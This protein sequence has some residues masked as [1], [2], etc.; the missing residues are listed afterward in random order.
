MADTP[1]RPT[2]FLIAG[3]N[4]A[5]KSTFYDTV[6]AP[7]V[8]APFVNADIIQRDDLR[9]P[10]PQ[11]SY[12]AA[13]MAE[14]RRRELLSARRSFVMETVFSHPSKLQLIRDARAQG[15]RV[16]VF[17]L[18][19]ASPE[20]AVARVRAR[21]QEGGHDVPEDKIRT[22]YDRNQAIIR[23]AALLADNAQVLDSSAR[24]Q[25]PRV[26]LE[27]SNGRAISFAK[28]CPAWFMKLYGDLID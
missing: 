24:N 25:K 2:L 14:T 1:P 9:D 7:M 13:R 19:V 26:L 3:P 12:E 27:L 10:S 4:G 6:V 21:R 16:V 18:N 17:H 15:F 11:A 8:A 22:R 5:G 23:A 20:I 28:Q